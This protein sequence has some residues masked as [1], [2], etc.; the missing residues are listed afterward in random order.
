MTPHGTEKSQDLGKTIISSHKKGEGYKKIS[1]AVLINQNTVRRPGRP[2]K[3]IEENRHA[4]SLQFAK[5]GES[6]TGVTVSRDIILLYVHHR[7]MACMARLEFARAHTKVNVS[8]TDGFKTEW[9]R[10]GEEY[11]EECM[12]P[13]VKHGGGRVLMRGCMSAAAV[14]ELHFIDGVMNSQRYCSILKEKI[15][16]SLHA[17][18]HRALF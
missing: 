16:P 2:R 15:L 8:G 6:Q 10:K 17:L 3:R 12:V 14:R 7:G 11:K 13:T 1:K 5:E 18:G 4:S 9:R